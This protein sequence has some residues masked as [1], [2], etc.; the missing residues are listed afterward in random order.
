MKTNTVEQYGLNEVVA[1]F[2]SVDMKALNANVALHNA[3][4]GKS[5]F[6]GSVDFGEKKGVI[7]VDSKSYGT[8]R[9]IFDS[10][11]R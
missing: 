7:R 11:R 6:T 8:T 4:E 10:P 1:K 9:E 3:F 2:Q 5:A